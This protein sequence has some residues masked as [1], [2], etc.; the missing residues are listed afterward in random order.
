VQC[1]A[2]LRQPLLDLARR[3]DGLADAMQWRFLFDG[4]RKVFA[5]NL[6][7]LTSEGALGRYGFFE[8]LAQPLLR[9]P[10]VASVRGRRLVQ[11]TG[12]RGVLDARVPFLR[13]PPLAPDGAG[14]WNDGMNRVGHLGRGESVWLGWFLLGRRG[15]P[16]Q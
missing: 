15:E 2:E 12:D 9:R 1:F 5:A 16:R 13:A 14:D 11:S 4:K 3:C 6:R 10:L 7:R 8:A